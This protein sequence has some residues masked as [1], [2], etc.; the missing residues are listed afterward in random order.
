MLLGLGLANVEW[1]ELLALIDAVHTVIQGNS[2]NS[3]ISDFLSGY[4]QYKRLFIISPKL[5]PKCSNGIL[6]LFT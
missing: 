6:P 1:S 5:T 2:I 3:F 4:W